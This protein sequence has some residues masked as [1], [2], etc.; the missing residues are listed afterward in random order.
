RW[1]VA[2]LLILSVSFAYYFWAHRKDTLEI[3]AEK[4]AAVLPAINKATL[5]LTDGQVVELSSGH[6]A[7]IIGNR[8]ITYSDGTEILNHGTVPDSHRTPGGSAPYLQLTT[9]K[10]GTYQMILP[11]GTRVWL[12]AGSTIKYPDHFSSDNRTIELEGEAFFAARGLSATPL[13]V[14]SQG[15]EVAVLGTEFNIAAYPGEKEI[16]T[17]LVTGSAR[18]T[19][20]IGSRDQSL[21]LKP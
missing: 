21:V 9:P 16:K 18:V 10:G 5:T 15:Q 13:I 8:E 12:N 20:H 2:A 19:A 14:K 1:M 17:T 11:D 6:D 4:A 3:P 7:I